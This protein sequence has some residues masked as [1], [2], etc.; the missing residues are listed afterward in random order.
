MSDI[1]KVDIVGDRSKRIRRILGRSLRQAIECHGADIAG[2][3]LVSWDMRGAVHSA[4]LADHGPVASSLVPSYT[5]D[6]LDR[7]L[8]VMLS[9]VNASRLIEGD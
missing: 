9:Q 5:K 6:A 2:F 7:H 4:Y 8:S 3:A 1:R